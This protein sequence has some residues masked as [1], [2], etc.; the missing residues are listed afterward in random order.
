MTKSRLVILFLAQ[1]SVYFNENF[2]CG[3]FCETDNDCVSTR[4]QFCCRNRP[5]LRIRRCK[6]NCIGQYCASDADCRGH[7]ECCSVLNHCTTYGC[8]SECITNA[9][10]KSGTYC[11]RKRHV[12]EKSL[13]LPKCV[14]EFCRSDTDCGGPQ[15]CC[16][17]LNHCTT[18]G[19]RHQC[20][21]NGDCSNDT[22]CCIKGHSFDK[23]SCKDSCLGE[24]CQSDRDCGNIGLCCGSDYFC[25]DKCSVNPKRLGA[26]I[27]T[28]IVI[29]IGFV[30]LLVGVLGVFYTRRKKW[31]SPVQNSV[32]LQPPEVKDPTLPTNSKP[33]NAYREPPPLPPPRSRNFSPPPDQALSPPSETLSRERRKPPSPPERKPD[34]IQRDPTSEKCKGPPPRP[35]RTRDKRPANSSVTSRPVA[36]ERRLPP[37]PPV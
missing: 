36:K 20:L 23:N 11:C 18:H 37:L 10:C 21:S 17:L 35:P 3:N 9:D 27:I 32:V 6:A 2:V 4:R 22:V 28:T 1:F 13:C 14:G 34:S 16:S 15:E 25:T 30:V 19:C 7:N 12:T 5:L 29:S 33:Q 26:W 31:K 8:P 24:S